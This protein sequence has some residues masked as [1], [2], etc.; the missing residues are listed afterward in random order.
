MRK[1]LLTVAVSLSVVA[2]I[3]CIL[4]LRKEGMIGDRT[5]SPNW[6]PSAVQAFAE[7]KSLAPSSTFFAAQN[8]FGVTSILDYFS[9]T[10]T[11]VATSSFFLDCGTSTSRYG[12]VAAPSD[13]LID[14]L[15]VATS[16][17]PE[18]MITGTSTPAGFHAGTNSQDRIVFGPT[19]WILCRGLTYV[20]GTCA[21]ATSTCT[22]DD[23]AFTNLSSTF[24]GTVKYRLI[25]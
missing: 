9:F 15:F 14:N 1:I 3:L 24:K 12:T 13:T 23:N 20:P 25:K 17:L 4:I 6:A 22:N 11:G 7:E 8:Y 5:L 18:Q 2:I 10:Q 19:D 16:T 21:T